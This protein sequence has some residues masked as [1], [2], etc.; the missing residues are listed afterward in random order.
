MP[1]ENIEFTFRFILAGV[2]KPV[3]V[4]FSLNDLVVH[5]TSLI[6]TSNRV[7]FVATLEDNQS[8]CL[9]FQ[10]L[11]LQQFTRITI[12][13]INI[14][15]LSDPAAKRYYNPGWRATSPNEV[16]HHTDITAGEKNDMY[17]K[18][19]QNIDLD[20][21]MGGNPSYIRKFGRFEADNGEVTDSSNLA[22][23]FN[24]MTPGTFKIDFTAPI[25]HWLYKNLI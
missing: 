2:Y 9:K 4:K 21:F 22:N 17:M 18:N 15:W 20:Y 3:P 11:E 24:L 5:E 23:M 12:A 13:N 14:K 6:N 1:G 25:S 16:W 19:S 10:I 7:G 8:Y